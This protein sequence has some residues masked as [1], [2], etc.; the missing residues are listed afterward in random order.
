MCV[1]LLLQLRPGGEDYQANIPG[2]GKS[3]N[4]GRSPDSGPNTNV[5][6]SVCYYRNSVRGAAAM[7]LVGHPR[8][9]VY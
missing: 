4:A 8:P 5:V 6:R 9:A 3:R 2:A 1:G 7:G